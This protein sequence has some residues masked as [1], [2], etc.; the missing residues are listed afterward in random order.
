MTQHVTAI[1]D[2]GVLKPLAP[3][4]LNDQEVVALSIEK[5]NES[6]IEPHNPGP[7]LY[8]SLERAGLIGC[9]KDAPA[10][11]STNPKYM[12]GFGKSGA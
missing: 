5:L 7:T 9:V 2:H 11:L 10:D 3:L 1:F 4:D 6:Q 12:E 8:E